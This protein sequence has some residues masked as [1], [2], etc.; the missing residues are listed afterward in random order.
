M[1]LGS[2]VKGGDEVFVLLGSRMPYVLHPM[3]DI[4]V[5]GLGETKLYTIVGEG[6]IHGIMDGELAKKP[7]VEVQELLVI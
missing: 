4:G 1:G 7:E 5:E 2:G 6:Y 3:G